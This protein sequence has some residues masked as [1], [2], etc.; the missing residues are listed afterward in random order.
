MGLI[1][2]KTMTDLTTSIKHFASLN[3]TPGATW[4]EATKRKVPHKNAIMR[5]EL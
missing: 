3:R 5:D 4:T 1:F 2:W